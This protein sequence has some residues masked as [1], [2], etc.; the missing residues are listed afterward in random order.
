MLMNIAWCTLLLSNYLVPPSAPK[1][2]KRILHPPANLNRVL[3][4]VELGHQHVCVESFASGVQQFEKQ[5]GKDS[6]QAE[7]YR[8]KLAVALEKRAALEKQ[9]D[10]A[11]DPQLRSDADRRIREALQYHREISKLTPDE[12][13]ERGKRESEKVNRESAEWARER[14]KLIR[15]RDGK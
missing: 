8:K 13:V 4:V 5:Y 10:D 11:D 2:M 6:G 9:I 12:L 3:L 14:E 7:F 1:P 15:I